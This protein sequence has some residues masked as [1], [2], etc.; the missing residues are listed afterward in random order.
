MYLNCNILHTADFGHEANFA[1]VCFVRH[2]QQD[3]VNVLLPIFLWML[4]GLQ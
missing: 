2:K 3:H 4:R 1:S